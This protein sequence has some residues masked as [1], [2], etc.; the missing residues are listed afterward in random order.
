MNITLTLTV[1]EVELLLKG[2]GELPYKDVRKLFPKIQKSA[3][4]QV[5]NQQAEQWQQNTT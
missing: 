2:L 5:N 1:E 3:Q 4:Q